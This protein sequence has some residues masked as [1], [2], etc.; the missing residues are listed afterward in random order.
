M[1][2]DGANENLKITMSLTEEALE[3]KRPGDFNLD[4][5]RKP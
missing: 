4:Q 5:P 2:D 3:A 1:R